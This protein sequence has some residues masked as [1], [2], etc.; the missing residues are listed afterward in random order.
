MNANIM[1]TQ[2]RLI[3]GHC[4]SQKD[5]F[6]FILTLTYFLMDKFLSLFIL[7]FRGI[8]KENT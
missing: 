5:T 2:I 4:R 7:R 1:N 8:L 6:M 3:D